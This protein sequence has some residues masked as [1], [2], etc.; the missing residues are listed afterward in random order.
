MSAYIESLSPEEWEEFC[1]IMLRYHYTAKNFWEV[2]DE[3]Q[4]D[5]GLEFFTIDGTLYQCYYPDLNVDMATYKR[6]IQR[7]ITEDLNKLEKYASEIVVLLD[8]IRVK[9]WVL[10]IP[11]LKSKE[12]ISHC[13]KKKK[14]L[15]KKNLPFIDSNVF[16]VKIETSASFPEGE[17]FAKN[18]HCKAIDI[19][20]AEVT[21]T[22]KKIWQQGNSEF[23]ANIV[24]KSNALIGNNS[25]E[26]QDRV[27]T[28]YIQIEKFLDQLRENHP[29]LHDLIEDSARAQLENMKDESLLQENLSKE[30]VKIIVKS[31]SEAFSKHSKFMSD[32]NIQSLSFGYLSK[33]LAECYMDF[34]D[35]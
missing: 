19:P 16:Q 9:Q 1:A 14:E 21:A 23:S 10:I 5:L 24:R 34:K 32:K 26:F 31:N 28:K 29:D 27:V 20:L 8:D 4:G 30:F 15:L 18:I 17:L 3:D 33:W 6:K 13:N 25:S 22:D 11:K 7:K 12:L 35:E 2:P